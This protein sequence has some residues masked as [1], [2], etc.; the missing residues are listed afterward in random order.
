MVAAVEVGQN[1]NNNSFGADIGY[2]IDS[3]GRT[4]GKKKKKKKKTQVLHAE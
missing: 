2:A 3:P 1:D 4:I